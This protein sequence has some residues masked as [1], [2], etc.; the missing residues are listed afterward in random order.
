MPY[1]NI[2]LA[3]LRISIKFY[4]ILLCYYCIIVYILHT[5]VLYIYCYIYKY[6]YNILLF[7]TNINVAFNSYFY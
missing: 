7:V 2:V 4:I 6:I 5:Y 1:K 3:N